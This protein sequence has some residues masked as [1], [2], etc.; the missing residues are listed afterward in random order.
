MKKIINKFLNIYSNICRRNYYMINS[1][2]IRHLDINFQKH[3][4]LD[5]ILSFFRVPFNALKLYYNKEQLIL[6][7]ISLYAT[8]KCNLNCESCQAWIPYN[9]DKN[10]GPNNNQIISDLD[11]FFDVVDYCY[12]FNITGGE[13]FL[14]R[15]LHEIINFLFENYSHR[16]KNASIVSNGTVIPN[17]ETLNIL[18]SEKVKKRL[19]VHISNYGSKSRKV[20][21][22]FKKYGVNYILNSGDVDWIEMGS[23]IP[24]NR[25]IVENKSIFKECDD[26]FRCNVIMGGRFY[27]CAVDSG[28]CEF[29]LK[30]RKK[31]EF[32]DLRNDDS[33]FSRKRKIINLKRIDCISA[34]DYCDMQLKKIYKKKKE[35][36]TK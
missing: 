28:L 4:K 36:N 16:F 7:Q 27:L 8:Y 1:E 12:R 29:N 35:I 14:N 31:Y 21:N 17:D 30:K 19:I 33:S 2:I 23:P 34:C 20:I 26:K 24:R 11:S 25:S 32:V 3:T 6:P 10:P 5:V 9:V 15:N 18:S 13:P 22:S